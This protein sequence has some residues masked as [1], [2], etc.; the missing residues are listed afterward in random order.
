M[1][2]EFSGQDVHIECLDPTH[3]LV[4]VQGPKAARCMA[5]ALGLTEGAFDMQ[6]FM[7]TEFDAFKF[8]G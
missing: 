8:N 6:D 7:I 1:G 4:A 3:S 5:M 2:E